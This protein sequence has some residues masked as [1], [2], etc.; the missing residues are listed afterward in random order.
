LRRRQDVEYAREVLSSGAGAGLVT[1]EQLA[2]RFAAGGPS[3]TLTER[4]G[5][6]R[7][8]TY[9]HI[10]VDE[11]QELTPM[12]W[13]ALLR[14]CPTRSLTIVG[15]AGQTR[16]PGAS[17]RWEGSL[18]KALGRGRWRLE[19]LSVNYRTPGEVVRAA[20]KVARAAGLPVGNDVAARE[21]RD[22]LVVRTV[23]D[24]VAEAVRI[25]QAHLPRGEVG[26][27][28]L[29]ATGADLAGVREAVAAGPLADKVARPD[30]NPLDFPL[31][32]LDASA[33]KGLEFDEVI[34]VGPDAIRASAGTETAFDRRTGAADLYVAMTRPTRRL[35]LLRPRASGGS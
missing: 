20:Q 21:V 26:R 23:D 29:I 9:G 32:I 5:A 16:S 18:D 2:D 34:I 1:A 27:V 10:V 17:G 8:W 33:T 22:A 4:A 25:A 14:R 24:P 19:E 12:D 3:L 13:R 35:W 11:A 15:D 28:A 7:A 31:S 6:D 30:E